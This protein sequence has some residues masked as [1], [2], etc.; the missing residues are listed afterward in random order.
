MLPEN[1]A[2]PLVCI[3]ITLTS[4][5][6]PA[7]DVAST[8]KAITDTDSD[9][10]DDAWETS[11]FG[12]LS[13]NSGG[14]FDSDGITNLEEHDHSLDPTID[15]RFSD[16]DRDGFPNIFELRNSASPSQAASTPSADCVVDPANA[17]VS[18]TDN[19]YDDVKACVFQG[20]NLTKPTIS[21]I[22]PGVD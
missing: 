5:H 13:Q 7:P 3:L 1:I 6:A 2:Q 16:Q 18:T 19:I 10:M 9:R 17:A 4:C 15:D 12:D 14:G 8:Q 11:N 22:E 20:R 21:E